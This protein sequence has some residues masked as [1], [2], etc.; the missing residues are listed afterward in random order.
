MAD[1]SRIE[2]LRR[3]V[4]KD[5]ASIAFAQLAEELRRARRF[6]GSGRRLPRRPRAPSRLSVRPRH[7]RTLPHRPQ[8]AGRCAAGARAGARQRSRK[9]C[10]HPRAGRHSAS[11][12]ARRG[13]EQMPEVRLKGR[14]LRTMERPTAPTPEV[15]LKPRRHYARQRGGRPRPGIAIGPASRHR[16][17]RNAKDD[18]MSERWSR[19]RSVARRH[20]C[21][22]RQ[23]KRLAAAIRLFDRRAPSDRSTRWSSRRCRTFCT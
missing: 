17:S 5:P 7:A 1:D 20:P 6:T 16:R 10:R 18:R 19:A 15:R 11:A 8:S 4:R 23:P 12:D 21:H 14:T 9:P 2:E 13:R 22:T 3:R